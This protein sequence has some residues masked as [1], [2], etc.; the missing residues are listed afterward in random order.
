MLCHSATLAG[1]W[2]GCPREPT[3]SPSTWQRLRTSS[4]S[5]VCAP[6]TL[7]SLGTT[8]PPQ[9]TTTRYDMQ[10]VAREI[11]TWFRTITWS[12]SR[13]I[14]WH[15]INFFCL[16]TTFN[17]IGLCHMKING[18]YG[19]L[20]PCHNFSM[21]STFGEVGLCQNSNLFCWLV[22]VSHEWCEFCC[23]LCRMLGW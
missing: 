22:G 6:R 2:L 5:L 14:S 18:D 19:D 13:S 3:G 15:L 20:E 16:Q 11:I 7:F 8:L 21:F 23:F 9:S 10:H 1:R 12:S 17:K 4:P